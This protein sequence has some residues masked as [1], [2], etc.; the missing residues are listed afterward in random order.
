VPRVRRQASEGS[1]EEDYI[2]NDDYEEEYEDEWVLIFP[3]IPN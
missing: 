3:L 1:G 2:E